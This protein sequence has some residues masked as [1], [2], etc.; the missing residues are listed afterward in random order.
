MQAITIIE[1]VAE[2][3]YSLAMK[4]WSLVAPF[5]DD[6][7]PLL[8]GLIMVFY[9]GSIPLTIAAVEAFRLTGWD[10]TKSALVVLFEQFN[11][12]VA[13]SKKDDQVDDNNDGIADVKQ[14]DSKALV[15]R[16]I[17]LFL[18]VT[19]PM[20]VTEAVTALGSGCTAV[21]ATLKNE[22]AQSITLGVSIADIFHKAAEKYLRP[23]LEAV[24]PKE[25]H[26]V[27]VARDLSPDLTL[28][29]TPV[30]TQVDPVW[31]FFCNEDGR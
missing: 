8:T 12:A 31:H 4:A 9:G 14:I 21:L 26:K 18:K 25:H 11:R 23:Q 7:L 10:R 19:D 16:K 17:S 30:C 13:A 15:Q 29:A 1:P 28:S 24:V 27:S 3:A 6:F 2:K 20:K 5:S 22:F